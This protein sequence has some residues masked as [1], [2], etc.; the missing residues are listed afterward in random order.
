MF[1]F[2]RNVGKQE[3]KIVNQYF[4]FWHA[5][6]P[7]GLDRWGKGKNWDQPADQNTGRES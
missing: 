7:N 1:D 2:I 6:L 4:I 3:E 5:D